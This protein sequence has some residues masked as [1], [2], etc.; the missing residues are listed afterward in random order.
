M[1]QFIDE[2]RDHFCVKFIGKTLNTHRIG[3]FLTCCGYRQYKS[4]GMSARCLRDAAPVE[5]IRKV[6]AANYGVYG[7]RKMWHA[8]RHEEINI[9]SE[10][11]ARLMRLTGVTD[12]GRPPMTT[13][14]PKGGLEYRPDLVGRAF[15][16]T[17]RQCLMVCVWGIHHWHRRI[18]L[19]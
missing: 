13:R 7:I 14:R 17:R 9:G 12:K 1:I 11:T 5:H 6:H 19:Q 8:L 15:Q 10:Q 3:G 18:N 16:T 2:Y 4:P